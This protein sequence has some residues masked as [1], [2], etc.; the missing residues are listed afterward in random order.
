MPDRLIAL[1]DRSFSHAT[2]PGDAFLAGSR[3]GCEPDETVSQFFGIPDW[4]AAGAELL[5]GC[6]D[7]LSFFSE[8][9]LRFFLP[10]Y[11]VADLGGRLQTADPVFHLTH[12]FLQTEHPYEGVSRVFNRRTGGAVLLNP[13]RY[14]AASWQDQARWRLSVFCR[15]EA[16]AIV[17]YL[18]FRRAHDTDGFDEPAIDAA[19]AAFWEGRAA[20]AP[21]AAEIAA[22]LAEE[23]AFAEDVKARLARRDDAG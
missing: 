14:G 15:E 8:G 12:G 3:D 1:I 6:Y 5:D 22:H 10:A 4:R 16:A 20:H 19:L 17:E 2:Y 13:L 23:Q 11:L 7:A 9:G 21:T 18:R